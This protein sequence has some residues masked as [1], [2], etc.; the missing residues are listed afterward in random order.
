MIFFNAGSPAS[1]SNISSGYSKEKPETGVATLLTGVTREGP[2][3]GTSF[4]NLKKSLRR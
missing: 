1:C 4:F 2:V 3:S